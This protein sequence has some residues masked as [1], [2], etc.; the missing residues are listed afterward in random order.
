MQSPEYEA[1]KEYYYLADQLAMKPYQGLGVR[2]DIRAVFA[3]TRC[4]KRVV[5][6]RG[7]LAR[8]APKCGLSTT[9][10]ADPHHQLAM[11][12]HDLGQFVTN[13]ERKP[14]SAKMVSCGSACPRGLHRRRWTP[15]PRMT[16]TSGT[17]PWCVLERM[18]FRSMTVRTY[19]G[20]EGLLDGPQ[21]GRYLPWPRGRQ[22]S[23]TRATHFV[24]GSAQ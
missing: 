8:I 18:E 20:K 1:R 6:V 13:R 15:S 19:E 17:E 7:Q 2:A 12:G 4:Q 23:T 9:T 3:P 16:H 11:L 10:L 21:S 5:K 14:Q 24:A 22:L